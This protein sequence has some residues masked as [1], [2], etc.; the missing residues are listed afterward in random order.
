MIEETLDFLR[1][2]AIFIK[3]TFGFH[4]YETRIENLKTDHHKLVTVGY[5]VCPHCGKSKLIFIF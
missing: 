3:C 1:Q 2:L 4:E 5:K